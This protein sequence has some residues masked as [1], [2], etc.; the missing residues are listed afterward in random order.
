MA[1]ILKQVQDDTIF[2]LNSVPFR[3]KIDYTTATDFIIPYFSVI[4]LS[5]HCGLE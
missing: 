4:A 5:R 1:E 3:K 2:T